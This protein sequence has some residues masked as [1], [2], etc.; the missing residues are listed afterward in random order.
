MAALFTVSPTQTNF[1]RVSPTWP[2]VARERGGL[3]W[4]RE[5]LEPKDDGMVWHSFLELVSQV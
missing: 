2:Y 3:S 4:S 1:S 5:K